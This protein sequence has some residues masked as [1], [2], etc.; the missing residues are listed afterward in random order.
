MVD[1]EKLNKRVKIVVQ[2][3]DLLDDSIQLE[4]DNT[5]KKWLKRCKELLEQL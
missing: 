3:R 1:F 2:I 5:I 4:Q